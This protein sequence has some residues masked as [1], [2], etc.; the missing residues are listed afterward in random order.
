MAAVQQSQRLGVAYNNLGGILK[1]QGRAPEAIACYEH[2]ALL[3]ADS[4]EAHA[5]LASAYKDAARQDTAIAS[6][7]RALQLRPDF[8]EAFANLVHSLQCICEW[9]DRQSLFMRLEGQLCMLE[10]CA[11]ITV[12]PL[13][14]QQRQSQQLKAVFQAL[15]L[16]MLALRCTAYCHFQH[17]QQQQQD[18]LHRSMTI[19]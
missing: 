8:P 13:H 19:Y 7:K 3:Q 15:H 10:V 1:M 11:C 12:T 17:F 5:N 18:V 4:P 16:L 9:Q 6:Y 14:M 2:V